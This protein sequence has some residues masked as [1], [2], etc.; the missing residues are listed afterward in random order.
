MAAAECFGC[1]WVTE[2]EMHDVFQRFGLVFSDEP[3]FF[4]CGHAQPRYIF[5]PECKAIPFAG[6]VHGQWEFAHTDLCPLFP[7]EIERPKILKTAPLEIR[8]CTRV[9]RCYVIRNGES[10][11]GI[12]L[13]PMRFSSYDFVCNWC[14][15]YGCCA[16]C[17]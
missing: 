12:Q 13:E 3:L 1:A 8:G 15:R 10:P 16:T 5:C 7:K 14:Q 9:V 4:S 6:L 17:S 11:E 2:E